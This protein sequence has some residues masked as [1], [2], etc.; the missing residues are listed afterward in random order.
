MEKC[1][2]CGHKEFVRIPRKYWMRLFRGSRLMECMKCRKG[3]L[4]IQLNKSDL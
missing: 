2:Y 1:P 3:F 4:N